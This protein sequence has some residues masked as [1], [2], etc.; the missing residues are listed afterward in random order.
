MTERSLLRCTTG[1]KDRSLQC[2][3][4]GDGM[5][6]LCHARRSAERTAG[7][8]VRYLR[9]KTAAEGG[10]VVYQERSRE[11]NRPSPPSPSRLA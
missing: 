4:A 7:D 11:R 2:G 6:I 1:G 9:R 3:R 5:R 8:T 10:V